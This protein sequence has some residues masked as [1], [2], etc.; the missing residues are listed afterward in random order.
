M[1]TAELYF[2]DAT[3]PG[4]VGEATLHLR[5]PHR[6]REDVSFDASTAGVSAVSATDW[7]QIF[8]DTAFDTAFG[9]AVTTVPASIRRYA[10]NYGH[11][12]WVGR[13]NKV[14]LKA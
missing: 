10:A 13:G 12:F 11:V 9:P 1:A 8:S 2:Y 6:S 4:S 7:V 3:A 14:A 5:E